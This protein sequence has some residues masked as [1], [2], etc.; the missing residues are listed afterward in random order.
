[1]PRSGYWKKSNGESEI[2]E[3]IDVFGW[4]HEQ[5]PAAC[6]LALT[7]VAMILVLVRIVKILR[8]IG[9]Q[10]YQPSLR[11]LRRGRRSP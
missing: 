9:R 11:P 10:P 3:L 5:W 8:L 2:A 7:V 6:I 1:M 4:T